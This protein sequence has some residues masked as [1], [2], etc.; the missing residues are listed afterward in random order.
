MTYLLKAR[1]RKHFDVL[2]SDLGSLFH[3]ILAQFS[4]RIWVGGNVPDFSRAEIS[5]IVGEL[6]SQITIDSAIF[7]STA[8]NRHILDKVRSVA[9]ASI[10]A[11]SEHL[12]QGK[13]KPSFTE[14]EIFLNPG[15]I[16]EDGRQLRLTGQVDRIDLLHSSDGNDYIK[17]IDYKS[18]QTKFDIDEV[19]Q[20]TQLQLMLYMNTLLKTLANV[21]EKKPFLPGGVFYFPIDDPIINADDLLDDPVR[22][23]NILK[24]FRMS[25]L[26]V[27]N[28]LAGM[29][30]SLAAG[31]SS[32]IIPVSL[33]KNGTKTSLSA[34]LD[35]DEFSQL[36]DE[37]N[38]IIKGIGDRM[39]QGDIV[40]SPCIL[41]KRNPCQYCSYSAI[42]GRK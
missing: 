40:A 30:V 31:T 11:L 4:K 29:D 42:C 17:V 10:W 20:G 27:E 37:V 21:D 8:R 25:G 36:G 1:E 18:G 34:I 38:A 3:D 16:L 33:N 32:S 12:K 9:T 26:T 35:L 13:F 15:I 5:Q 19:K 41:G 6:V 24:C 14:H 7:N 2:F 28:A 23:A 39:I 22:E